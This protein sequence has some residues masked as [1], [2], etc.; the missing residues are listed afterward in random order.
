[1]VLTQPRATLSRTMDYNIRGIQPITAN[2]FL[3]QY[4]GRVATDRTCVSLVMTI[5]TGTQSQC[6]FVFEEG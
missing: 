2:R 1:M 4:I 3:G 6:L 5:G